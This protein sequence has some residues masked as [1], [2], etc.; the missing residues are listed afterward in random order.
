MD[1]QF[2]VGLIA[3]ILL[4]VWYGYLVYGSNNKD[5]EKYTA[6]VVLPHT[7]YT[8]WE[9]K[10][11]VMVDI[12]RKSW[13]KFAPGWEIIEIN[14]S[15]VYQYLEK[16]DLPSNFE[17]LD[18]V[19]RKADAVRLNLL[20]KY[21]G[22]WCD[23]TILMT[24]DFGSWIEDEVRKYDG[25]FYYTFDQ[26]PE[27]WFIAAAKNNEFM[28]DWALG[29][30][31]EVEIMVG[32]DKK[33]YPEK[34]KVV[35]KGDNGYLLMNNTARYLTEHKWKGRNLPNISHTDNGAPLGYVAKLKWNIKK[36]KSVNDIDLTNVRMLKLRGVER[37]YFSKLYEENDEAKRFFDRFT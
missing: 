9:G 13:E 37:R 15:N 28:K 30:N 7:I 20:R 34:S 19:A 14:P 29:F 22:V 32:P 16:T 10:R 2:Y 1:F 18:F 33:S 24:T 8:Y 12:C 27:G 11:P 6:D 5:Q 36:L 26:G 4:L 23:A 3:V 21:G 25:I 17:N 31:E 35:K